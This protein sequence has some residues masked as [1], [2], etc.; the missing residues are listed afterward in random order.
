MPALASH[1]DAGIPEGP[2]TRRPRSLPDDSL[3]AGD[4]AERSHAG[5]GLAHC[6]GKAGRRVRQA[7]ERSRQKGRPVAKAVVY[8][9]AEGDEAGKQRR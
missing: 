6:G 2:Q 3:V 9:N 1:A 5:R 8:C 4:A 7:V